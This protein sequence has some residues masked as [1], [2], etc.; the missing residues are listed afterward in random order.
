MRARKLSKNSAP[1]ISRSSGAN[2]PADENLNSQPALPRAVDCQIKKKGGMLMALRRNVRKLVLD[3][4]SHP[5]RFGL[6]FFQVFSDEFRGHGFL[7]LV[8]IHSIAFGGV[9][10]NIVV[11][12]GGSQISRIQQSNLQKQFAQFGLIV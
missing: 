7:D 4:L 9:R 12:G 3:C 6:C 2:G 1:K 11:A 5:T 10:Q 8:S